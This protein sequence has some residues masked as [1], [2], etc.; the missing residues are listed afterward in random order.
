MAIPKIEIGP[1]RRGQITVIRQPLDSGRQAVH[2]AEA[3]LDGGGH[4]I[5]HVFGGYAGGGSNEAHCLAIAAVEGEGDP[6]L[7][8]VVAADLEPVRAPASVAGIDRDAPVVA[9]LVCLAAVP[10]E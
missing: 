8:A 1:L 7:L 2:A 4:E 9:T 10:L 6:H 5:A 3:V